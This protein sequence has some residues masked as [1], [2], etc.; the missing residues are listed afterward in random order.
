MA[1]IFALLILAF[2]WVGNAPTRADQQ[3]GREA[4][5]RQQ[6]NF[7]QQ[8]K[9]YAQ[10]HDYYYERSKLVSQDINADF[11]SDGSLRRD[12]NTGKTYSKGQYYV[13][14]RGQAA[15]RRPKCVLNN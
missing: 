14:S 12:S 13:D 15:N 4:F 8:N 10:R 5:D 3:L 1:I 9:E 2:L 11:Y 6:E 7:H